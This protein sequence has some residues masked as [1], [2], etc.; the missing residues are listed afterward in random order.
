M[1]SIYL[2]LL[3]LTALQIQAE[4]FVIACLSS[5][6]PTAEKRDVEAAF[7]LL[8]ETFL[9]KVTQNAAITPIF[10]EK[11]EEFT[12][13]VLSGKADLCVAGSFEYF[14]TDLIKTMDPLCL[15][16]VSENGFGFTSVLIAQKGTSLSQLRGKKL[17]LYYRGDRILKTWIDVFLSESGFPRHEQFFSSVSLVY[18][19]NSA[20][21]PVM[22]GQVDACLIDLQ[23]FEL[24]TELNPQINR[25]LEVIGRSEELLYGFL[26]SKKSIDPVLKKDILDVIVDMHKYSDSRQILTLLQVY[27][28]IEMKE[29]YLGSSL[30]LYEKY[31]KLNKTG[32]IHE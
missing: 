5:Y 26:A 14:D 30:K 13:F 3:F 12:S 4:N 24:M 10:F 7:S 21:V 15:G 22:F 17:L 19:P 23:A 28:M 16:T 20:I 25:K 6:F 29:E 32:N 9:K 11:P 2:Y 18:K 27:R 8:N 1:K 31:Q